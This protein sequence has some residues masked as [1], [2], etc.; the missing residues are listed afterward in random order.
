MTALK[1]TFEPQAKVT[2][3]GTDFAP[4]ALP[5]AGAIIV[6]SFSTMSL[7][8]PSGPAIDLSSSRPLSVSVR[9]LPPPNCAGGFFAPTT[10]LNVHAFVLA[11]EYSFGLKSTGIVSPPSTRSSAFWNPETAAISGASSYDG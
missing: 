7:M 9:G 5:P 4:P 8:L 2:K 11:T 3:G 1:V 6:K 10:G